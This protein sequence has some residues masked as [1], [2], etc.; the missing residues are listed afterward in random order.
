MDPVACTQSCSHSRAQAATAGRPRAGAVSI[1]GTASLTRIGTRVCDAL[2]PRGSFRQFLQAWVVQGPRQLPALPPHPALTVPLQTAPYL[3]VW[4]LLGPA[5]LVQPPGVSDPLWPRPCLP[6][7]AR[8]RAT[9]CAPTPH[10]RRCRGA[11]RGSSPHPGSILTG[12]TARRK[13][14]RT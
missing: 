13:C 7:Q 11:W 4:I 14:S 3:P 8:P 5:F 10:P 2:E 1:H 6:S 9:G 12:S